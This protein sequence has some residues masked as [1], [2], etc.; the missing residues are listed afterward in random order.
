MIPDV[1]RNDFCFTDG[2]GTI[3]PRL[4]DL[5]SQR[6]R[7]TVDATGFQI[8]LQGAKGVLVVDKSLEGEQVCLRPSM[9]KF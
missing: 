2:C 6:F 7:L 4:A 1:D 8:R 3:S 5:I 9:V